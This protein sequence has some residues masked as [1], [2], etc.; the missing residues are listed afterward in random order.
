MVLVEID[1]TKLLQQ[2]RLRAQKMVAQGLYS[3]FKLSEQQR[4]D[5]AQLGCMGELAF[6]QLLRQKGVPYQL[7][8]TDFASSRTD[9]YD[10]LIG[11]KKVDVKVA[12]KTS[13]RPPGDAWTYGYPQEQNPA[14]KDVV[15]VGWVDL[16]RQQVGFWGWISGKRICNYPVVSRNSYAGYAYL[17]PNYEF[18]W[19]ALNKNID[20]ILQ[21]FSP[22]KGR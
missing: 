7:D 8:A 16:A 4:L 18:P 11:N 19:G 2:A 1:F 22:L 10:F 3:R 6:E 5:K 14:A 12:K 13:P 9:Q 20:L 15:V 21:E 17:T